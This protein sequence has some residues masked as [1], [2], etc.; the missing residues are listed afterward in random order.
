MSSYYGQR[1]VRQRAHDLFEMAWRRGQYLRLWGWLRRENR[2]LPLLSVL[3]AEHPPAAVCELGVQP[4]RLAQVIGTQGKISFDKDFLP[5]QRRS[6]NRWVSVAAAALQDATALPPI[7]VVK[8]GD[9]YYVG[10]GNHRVSVAKVLD[11]LYIDADVTEWLSEP[12]PTTP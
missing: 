3:E 7:D 8:V 4:V 5:V 11:N 10:D 1:Q 12:P 9:A 6:K 2:Q